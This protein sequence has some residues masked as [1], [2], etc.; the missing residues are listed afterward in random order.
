M[1]GSRPYALGDEA[2]H[3]QSF[4]SSDAPLRKLRATRHHGSLAGIWRR[5]AP[6]LANLA[7]P[8]PGHSH[9]NRNSVRRSVTFFVDNARV[10]DQETVRAKSEEDAIDLFSAKG[11]EAQHHPGLGLAEARSL[12]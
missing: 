12:E 6:H 5:T 9:G 10:S 1:L 7:S 11:Q 2:C 4:H 8:A 3:Y